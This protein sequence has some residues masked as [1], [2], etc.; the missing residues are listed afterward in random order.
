LEM[1]KLM[2]AVLVSQTAR[3]ALDF[4]LVAWLFKSIMLS[5]LVELPVCRLGAAW[6]R[7]GADYRESN[8]LLKFSYET[9]VDTKMDPLFL[10]LPEWLHWATC[11]HAWFFAPLYLALGVCLYLRH[12]RP[13][14]LISAWIGPML[15][16]ALAFVAVM[17]RYSELKSPNFG[18]W[19]LANLDYLFVGL[20]LP[21][22]HLIRSADAQNDKDKRHVH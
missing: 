20:Y 7:P 17:E 15:F 21:F 12:R 10:A 11:L 8:F 19:A 16:Y 9:L 4:V 2:P 6:T 22:D 1:T 5:A 18:A 13:A 14:K 3:R